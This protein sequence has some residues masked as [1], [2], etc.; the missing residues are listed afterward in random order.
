MWWNILLGTLAALMVI[1]LA[2][3]IAM[4]IARPKGSALSEA[5]RLLPALLRLLRRLYSD[6]SLPRSIRIRLALLL[7][8]LAFP[9]DLIPDFIPVLGYADDAIIAVL[10]LRSVVRHAGLKTVQAHWP[11]TEAGFTA[12]CRLTGLTDTTR[13]L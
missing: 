8:Y 2:L 5:L 11:G 6:R 13:D 1:W 9:I 10:V 12:L 7:A 3:I 4:A